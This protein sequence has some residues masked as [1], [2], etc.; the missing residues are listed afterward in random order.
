MSTISHS[1][2]IE[3]DIDDLVRSMLP[4]ERD[5]MI[6]ALSETG[7]VIPMG[8]G[9]GDNARINNLIDTAFNAAQKIPNLPPEIKDLFYIVHGRAMA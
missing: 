2:D 6:A 9:D 7:A 5:D 1:A 3:I 8:M 4:R